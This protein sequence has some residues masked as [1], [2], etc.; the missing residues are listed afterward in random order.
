MSSKRVMVDMS[1]TIIHHG[2]IRILK[3]AA[4]LGDVVVGLTIDKDII[5]Y[6]GYQPE[7]EFKHRREILQSIK[8]VNEVVETP[9]L[10]TQQA[11]NKYKIDILLHGDDNS[12]LVDKKNLVIMARTKGVSSSNIRTKAF[13][14]IAHINNQKLMLTP[15]PASLPYESLS[16]LK[17]LFGRG[18]KEY[19][20]ISQ[21]V[22]DWIKSLTGQ[23]EVVVAQGSATFAL[24]LSAHTFLAGR[25]LLISTGY[26]SDRLEKLLPKKCTVTKCKYEDVEFIHESYDWIVSAYV[27]TSTAFKVDIQKVKDKASNLGAKLFLDA[28]GSIGLEEDHYLADVMAFSS[29]KG[30]FGIT[31]ACFIAYKQN[32]KIREQD[33]FYFNLKTH[34]NHMVTGA[35]HAIASLYAVKDKHDIF[36]QRAKKSK[37][38]ILE[39]YTDLLG[40]TDY[41]PVLCTYLRGK[42]EKKDDNIVLYETRSN[43]SGSIICHIGEIHTDSTRIADRVRVIPC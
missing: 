42:I 40:R 41:Q 29:C 18:D 26:Y 14:S 11:L 28:T 9:W 16:Y 34:K 8:Y 31:G 1:A 4:K 35:Y 32:L 27:D 7:L 22:I 12:N 19:S 10:I 20:V 13:Q 15:G 39:K 5:K 37:K 36:K 24:E 33:G 38:I 6:K 30:L 21:D 23:D 25:V 17:P 43:L 3:K 2:H